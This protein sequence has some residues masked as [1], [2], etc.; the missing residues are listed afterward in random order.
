[1]TYNKLIISGKSFTFDTIQSGNTVNCYENEKGNKDVKN[2]GVE[3][4]VTFFLNVLRRLKKLLKFQKYKK[5]AN[6][7]E[8]C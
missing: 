8:H 2:L 1:M 7:Y 5:K 3:F 6:D 4:I